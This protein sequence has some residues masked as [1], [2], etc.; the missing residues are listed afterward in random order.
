MTTPREQEGAGFRIL[1][2]RSGPDGALEARVTAPLDS[3]WFDGHFPGNP[4]L[5]GIA[6]MALVLEL[7]GRALDT[8]VK[9]LEFKRVRFKKLIRPEDVIT[10]T[11][12][13]HGPRPAV[14]A[15]RLDTGGEPACT[16]LIRTRTSHTHGNDSKG[17]ASNDTGKDH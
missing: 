6:Q 9:P 2:S 16:G 5:P 8:G 10:V 17:E 15:F 3:A 14:F 13:P 7:L 4:V 12:G 1:E 11:V